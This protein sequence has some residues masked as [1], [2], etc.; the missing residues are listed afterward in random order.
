ADARSVHRP[1]RAT[2]PPDP[3]PAGA[4][5]TTGGRVGERD[6]AQP[7]GRLQAPARAPRGRTGGGANRRAAADL[8]RQTRASPSPRPVARALPADVVRAPRRARAP[9]GLDPN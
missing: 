2:A 8:P 4:G 3:R 7:A 6:R 5:R 9:S 1:R